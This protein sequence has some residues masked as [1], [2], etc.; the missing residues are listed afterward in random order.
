[1]TP[2][3]VRDG[4][5][6]PMCGSQ[7]SKKH[8]V[9][10][11]VVEMSAQIGLNTVFSRLLDRMGA[12]ARS[13][14]SSSYATC[15]EISDQDAEIEFSKQ[16]PFRSCFSCPISACCPWKPPEEHPPHTLSAVVLNNTVSRFGDGNMM[17][18]YTDPKQT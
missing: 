12:A 4:I 16:H 15:P 5:E 7:H 18:C 17:F 14:S 8:F 6:K 13:S 1:V 11:A 10:G 3:Y 2:Q 9:V